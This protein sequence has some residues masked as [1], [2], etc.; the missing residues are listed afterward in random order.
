MGTF[1]IWHWLI[2][3][4]IYLLV[5]II[6]IA[7]VRPS[8]RVSRKTFAI[9]GSVIVVAL[10]GIGVLL[11]HLSPDV[12]SPLDPELADGL[13]SLASLVAAIPFV[14]WSSGRAQDAGWSKWR[15]L[16]F[17]VPVA[18]IILVIQLLFVETRQEVT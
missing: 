10:I 17:M 6:P 13:L 3:L 4:V 14:R 2:V 5:I 11:G 15:C 12:T 9:R 16:V 1:S 8:T 7:T 18:N